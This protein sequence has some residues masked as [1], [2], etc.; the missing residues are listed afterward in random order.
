METKISD[1]KTRN[2]KLETSYLSAPKFEVEPETL[3]S[4]L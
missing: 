1:F 2:Q 4:R 3:D